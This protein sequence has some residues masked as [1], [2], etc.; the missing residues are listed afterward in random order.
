MNTVNFI[1]GD[2]LFVVF[3]IVRT[4]K[5]LYIFY[6]HIITYKYIIY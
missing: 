1:V 6:L 4:Q 2:H 3:D 5:I